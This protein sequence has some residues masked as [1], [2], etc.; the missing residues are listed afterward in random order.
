MHIAW[1]RDEWALQS[2]DLRARK[3][4]KKRAPLAL[5]NEWHPNP[6]ALNQVEYHYEPSILIL[7]HFFT[8]LPS[9][10]IDPALAP[11]EADDDSTFCLE[12][13]S[14]RGCLFQPRFGDKRPSGDSGRER[15]RWYSHLGCHGS[16]VRLHSDATRWMVSRTPVNTGARRAIVYHGLVTVAVH[17]QVC[18]DCIGSNGM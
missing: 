6:H 14:K 2:N 9:S 3:L 8:H 13:Q 7:R 12:P 5:M 18:N 16:S 10:N 15:P 4:A 1:A 17:V 11:R